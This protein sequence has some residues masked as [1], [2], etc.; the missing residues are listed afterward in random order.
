MFL[1]VNSN[2]TNKDISYTTTTWLP[3]NIPVTMPTALSPMI[4]M[5]GLMCHTAITL[6][7][8]MI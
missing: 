3:T 6:V 8:A 2:L 7:M 1:L 5:K 4:T